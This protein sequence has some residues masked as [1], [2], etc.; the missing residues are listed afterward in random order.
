MRLKKLRIARINVQAGKIA[1]RTGGTAS[2][3]EIHRAL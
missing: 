1:G 3:A 2:L